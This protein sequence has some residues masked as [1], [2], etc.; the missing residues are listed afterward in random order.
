MYSATNV[1]FKIDNTA[2]FFS[3]LTVIVFHWVVVWIK[4]DNPCEA[5]YLGPGT[6]KHLLLIKYY[7]FLQHSVNVTA[8]WLF[9]HRGITFVS[10]LGRFQGWNWQPWPVGQSWPTYLFLYSAQERILFKFL[11]VVG[12]ESK[13]DNFVTQIQIPVFLNKFLLE[14][15]HIYSLTYYLWLHLCCSSID[16]LQQRPCGLKA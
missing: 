7:L 5:L 1:H 12:R 11:V 8:I 15:S 14:H 13:E 3:A 16:E 4:Q 10:S 9:Y 2:L 6:N